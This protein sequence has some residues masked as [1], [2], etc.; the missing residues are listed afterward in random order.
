METPYR[1]NAILEDIL[2]NCSGSTHLCV[3]ADITA[4]SEFIKTLEIN[5]WKKM[6]SLPDLHKR[7]T[8]FLLKSNPKQLSSNSK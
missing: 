3:A 5:S 2:N 7:P 6:A 4:E 8:I 1:N